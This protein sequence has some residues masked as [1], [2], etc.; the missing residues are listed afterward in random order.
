MWRIAA[1]LAA[2]DYEGTGR[3]IGTGVKVLG[4]MAKQRL[5][6]AGSP[7]AAG[8]GPASATRPLAPFSKAQDKAKAV[9]AGGAAFG[10]AVAGPFAKAGHV[11]WL[12]TVGLFFALFAVGFMAELY[13]VRSQWKSGPEHGHFLA[14][15][16]FSVVFTYFCVTSFVR[17]RR[18]GRR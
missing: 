17:A 15:A 10:K 6:A 16:A 7:A 4:R 9:K 13:K 11:L 1:I 14:Y 12:E 2:V 3:K 18:R 8:P 5:D